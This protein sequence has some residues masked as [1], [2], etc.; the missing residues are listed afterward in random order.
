MYIIKGILLFCV[1]CTSTVIGIII[2]KKYENRVQILKNIKNALNIFEVKLNFTC[3]TIP[4]IFDE[5]SEKIDGVAGKVFKIAKEQ[6]EQKS[7]R[8]SLGIC[9]KQ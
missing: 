3:E 8:R 9:N 4:E 7:A 5:I 2:S 6:M 1:F